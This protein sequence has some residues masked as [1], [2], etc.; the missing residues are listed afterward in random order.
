MKIHTKSL[1]ICSIL[2]LGSI[3]PLNNVKAEDIS[4]AST[5]GKISFAENGGNNKPKDP[6]NPT[7]DP[8]NPNENGDP[9]DNNHQ[10]GN[11]GD[12]TLTVAPNSFDFGKQN[13]YSDEHTYSAKGDFDQYLQVD[14][15]RDAGVQG[16]TL[17]AK[18]DRDLT[19][20]SNGKK[21]T[22]VTFYIPKGNVHNSIDTNN[23]G[24]NAS[25]ATVDTN[26]SSIIFSADKNTQNAGKSTSTDVWKSGNVK[27]TIPRN[28]AIS[29]NFSNN[30]NW[31][32]T[33][34]AD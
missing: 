29:G 30:I 1:L 3:I 7:K 10:T 9:D 13:K 21:M 19:D 33:A 23:E 14:D 25:D 34:S 18:Q 32:L 20:D 6:N 15:N 17:T 28:T 2:L 8:N 22:G 5:T 24:L 26:N 31:T 16:W 4:T 12:L 27:L 11:T